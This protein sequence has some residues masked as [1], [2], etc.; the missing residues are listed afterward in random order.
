M[1]IRGSVWGFNPVHD[2]EGLQYKNP[3][4]ANIVL[5]LG[6]SKQPNKTAKEVVLMG[7][8]SSGC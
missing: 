2:P 4:E 3:D 1:M 8:D 6:Q 7:I 5:N